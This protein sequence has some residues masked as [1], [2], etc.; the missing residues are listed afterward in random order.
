MRVVRAFGREEFERKRFEKQN[1]YYTGL[2]V[3]LMRLMAIF[4]GIG[5]FISGLQIMLILVLGSIYC[6]NGSLSAGEFIAFLSYNSMLIWPVRQLGRVISEMSKA[7]ISIDRIMYIMNSPV[8]EDKKDAVS[9]EE[10]DRAFS[11]DIVFDH[12]SFGYDGSVPVLE[13]VSFTIPAGTTFGILG[14]TGSGKSTLMHLLDR[15]YDLPE[16]NG[17]I[18]IGGIDIRDMKVQDLRRRIGMVLQEPF[19]FSRT[20][21][22]NIGITD[23]NMSMEEIRNAAKIACV[24]DAITEF[25]NGSIRWSA[26]EA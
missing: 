11:G 2:W 3:S 20:I 17:K 10:T 12:V 25:K 22:E 1:V 13:D 9:E 23:R 7:G 19:L 26:R 21:S 15:L 4:W 8:E 24:D 14:S 18:T 5:D 16:E 6:V